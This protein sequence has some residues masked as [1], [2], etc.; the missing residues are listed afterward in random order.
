MSPMRN[1]NGT[2]NG[3]AVMARA[4]GLS[5]DEV[6]WTFNR[7]QRLMYREKRTK[8]EALAI[9]REEAKA[10]PWLTQSVAA[11]ES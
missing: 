11:G 4:S 5:E 1:A 8:D 3:V 9:V 7:L 6:A 2:W 10:K